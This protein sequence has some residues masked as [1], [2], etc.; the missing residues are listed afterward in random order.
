MAPAIAGL[1]ASGSF[2]VLDP[3]LASPTVVLGIGMG[4]FKQLGGSLA[5]ANAYGEVVLGEFL[6][7]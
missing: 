3:V 7:Q 1:V 2:T 6:T 5:S 4:Y